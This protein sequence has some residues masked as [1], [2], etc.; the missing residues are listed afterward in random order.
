MK[1]FYLRTLLVDQDKISIIEK[2]NEN[3]PEFKNN[4]PYFI[5]RMLSIQNVSND[6]PL[7]TILR[8]FFIVDSFNGNIV[9]NEYS[10]SV[11]K[12]ILFP[13]VIQ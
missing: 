11:L 3:R 5:S 10:N 13:K 7:L 4:L 1:F 2:F 6:N 9:D 12:E 8:S